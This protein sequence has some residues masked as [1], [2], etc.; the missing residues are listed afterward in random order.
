MGRGQVYKFKDKMKEREFLLP[1]YKLIDLLNPYYMDRKSIYEFLRKGGDFCNQIADMIILDIGCGNKPYKKIFE[2]KKYVGVDIEKSGHSEELKKADIYYDG[3]T[4]PVEDNSV[5]LIISTQVFE[6]IYNIEEIIAEC[7]RVLKPHGKM[8]LTCP[9]CYEEHEIP[10]DYWRYTQY[11]IKSL[12][13]KSGFEISNC[14]KSLSYL[15]TVR[16]LHCTY[17]VQKKNSRRNFINLVYYTVIIFFSNLSYMLSHKFYKQKDYKN[18]LLSINIFLE[19]YK[20]A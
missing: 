12:L 8:L 7:A 20:D 15:D 13:R 5:D 14:E 11:G 18:S 1:G 6:H 4:L 17:A 2:G 19:C 3:H 9:L 16:F 10:Y